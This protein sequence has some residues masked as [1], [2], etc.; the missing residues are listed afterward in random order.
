MG[1]KGLKR[2]CLVGFW[3]GDGFLGECGVGGYVIVTLG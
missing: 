3:S 2:T 1:L